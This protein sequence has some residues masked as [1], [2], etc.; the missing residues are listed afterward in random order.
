[1]ATV[2]RCDRCGK[3]IEMDCKYNVVYEDKEYYNK[4]KT[5]LDLCPDCASKLKNFLENKDTT[6][7]GEENAK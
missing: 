1:M 2:F 3:I 4:V 6:I 5:S 7:T